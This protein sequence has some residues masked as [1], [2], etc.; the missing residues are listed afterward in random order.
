MEEDHAVLNRLLKAVEKLPK[1]A[2]MTPIPWPHL[3]SYISMDTEW[4]AE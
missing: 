1:P 4:S 2:Q 3:P